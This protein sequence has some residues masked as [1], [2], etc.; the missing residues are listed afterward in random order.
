MLWNLKTPFSALW[1]HH[2]H[3]KTLAK[4]STEIKYQR[5]LPLG[6][7]MVSTAAMLTG[8]IY[9][10]T[11]NDFFIIIQ[12]YQVLLTQCVVF[13]SH[14]ISSEYTSTHNSVGSNLPQ[15]LWVIFSLYLLSP[16]ELKKSKQKNIFPLKSFYI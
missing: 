11:R 9:N 5:F 2:F 4:H 12:I 15:R 7:N 10:L 16:V 13:S 14:I 6:R 1:K 8:L 3:K